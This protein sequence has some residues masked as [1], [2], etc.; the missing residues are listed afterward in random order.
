M[1]VVVSVVMVMGMVMASMGQGETYYEEETQKL[2]LY[3][4]LLHFIQYMFIMLKG[5]RGCVIYL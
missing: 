3:S 4:T 1:L 2:C 5:E